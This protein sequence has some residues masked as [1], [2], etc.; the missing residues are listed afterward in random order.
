MVFSDPIKSI[1]YSNFL[2]FDHLGTHSILPISPINSFF[3]RIYPF[4]FKDNACILGHPV[5]A[6]PALGNL[7]HWD[8]YYTFVCINSTKHCYSKRHA[9]HLTSRQRSIGLEHWTLTWLG[10]FRSLWPSSAPEFLW[11]F[12]RNDDSDHCCWHMRLIVS[13]LKGIHKAKVLLRVEVRFNY[14]IFD[15]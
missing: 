4:H 12:R 2:H 14:L 5:Y 15:N 8:D 6:A 13:S 10:Q 11:E 3:S 7:P 1:N 9:C